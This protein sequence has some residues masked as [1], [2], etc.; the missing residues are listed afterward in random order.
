MNVFTFNGG[1]AVGHISTNSWIKALFICGLIFVAT[2]GARAQNVPLTPIENS[3]LS[4]SLEDGTLTISGTGAM[5]DYF[6]NGSDI[7][8]PWNSYQNSITTV[9]IEDGVTSI[10]INAFSSCSSLTSVTIPNS[11]TSIGDS[12]FC[13][14][15]SLTSVT[16]PN[17]VTSIGDS[18]FV[19]CT[20]LASIDVADDN[21][22]YASEGGVLF[23]K[24][25]TILVRY[26]ACK[27]NAYTIPNSVTTIGDNAFYG[28]PSLTSVTISNSVTTIGYC[29]FNECSSLTSVT[30]PNSVTYIGSCAFRECNLLSTTI[31]NSVTT[32]GDNAFGGN[33]NLKS[34]DVAND[35]TAYA[36][37]NGILFNKG[38]TTLIKYPAGKSDIAYIIPNTVTSIEGSAFWCCSSLTSVTITNSVTYIGIDAFGYCSGLTSIAIPNSVTSEEV[39]GAFRGCSGLTSIILPNSISSIA[40]NAF[41]QCYGLTSVTILNSVTLIGPNA[42][43]GL[44]A[45]TE[46]INYATTPQAI[47]DNDYVFN[48]VNLSACT[49]RVPLGSSAAY[50]AADVWQDFVNIVEFVADPHYTAVTQP[51][52]DNMTVTA[53]VVLN[54]VESQSDHIEIGAFCGDECRGSIVLQSYPDNT[55]HPYLGFLVVHGNAGDNITFRVFN[56]D[57]GK[58]YDATN[59]PISFAADAINGDPTAPYLVDAT[60]I[61]TQT[62]PLVSGWSWVSVN[63]ADG[64]PSLLDQFKTSVGAAGNLLKGKNEFIQ[65]PGWIGTL[66]S[67]DNRNMYMVNTT[68]AGSLSFTGLQVNP[69][70]TPISLLSGWNWIG[71]LPQASLSID[72]ALAGMSPQDGDQIK[73]RSEYSSYTTGT[74][75]VGTLE[76]MNPGDGFKYFSTSDQA[77][78]YPST[79]SQFRSVTAENDMTTEWTPN[80]NS[81]PNTMTMTSVV[82]SGSTELQSDQIEIGA[83]S[84]DECRGSALLKN[85]PQLTDHP[86]LGF[87]V[88]YGNGNEAIRL[89][90]YNHATGQVYDAS[91]APLSFSSDAIYGSP[92]DPYSV[93]MPSPTGICNLSSGSVSVYMDQTGEKLNIS[94]PWNVIDQVAI[95]DLTGRIV[96]QTTGFASESVNVSSL[97]KGAYIVKLVKDGQMSVY[98]FVKK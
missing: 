57:T 53:A 35:N 76:T 94:Y 17:S 45:L 38:K 96:W 89:R 59:A 34:I 79:S 86:Y 30:I 49:L 31:P 2:I 68:A 60:D 44:N 88:V 15:T 65:T 58:E 64:N 28:C 62:I 36:S 20:S 11:V 6:Y 52:P 16:I 67:I 80:A 10:G 81:F 55:E 83:F 40:A 47:S 7:T 25:K 19:N 87:L 37:E 48:G 3:T 5:P 43:A 74:G 95:V 14:C 22:A 41:S 33:N 50:R 4:W 23:D 13:G 72:D 51:Y 32:I 8:T 12:A 78:V 84:G 73:S 56:H 82:L 24:E 75:W 29:A 70:Y 92:S 93:V 71:Y 21:T 9:V 26:P 18:A 54:N 77:L 61:Y 42:F 98:K 39:S 46:I 63:I 1:N 90:I 97:A 91:N 85:F 66:S 27:A 69:V